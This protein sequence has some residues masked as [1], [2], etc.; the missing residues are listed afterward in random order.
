MDRCIQS[1]AAP[2]SP[3]HLTPAAF[4]GTF[5]ATSDQLCATPTSSAD[6]P[7]LRARRLSTRDS[8][9]DWMDARGHSRG[10][11]ASAKRQTLADTALSLAFKLSVVVALSRT[12]HRPGSIARVWGLASPTASKPVRSLASASLD[13]L[14]QGPVPNI[15]CAE[16]RG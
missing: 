6:R 15:R 13:H 12:G 1:E 2:L 10:T 3:R 7:L 9:P 8:R 14:E 16:P 4:A 11:P 5:T